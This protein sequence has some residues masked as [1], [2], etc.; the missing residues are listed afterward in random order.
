[1]TTFRYQASLDESLVAASFD[2]DL[3]AAVNQTGGFDV[4]IEHGEPC[5]IAF[6]LEADDSHA[7]L[8]LGGQVIRSVY[9]GAFAEGASRIIP[10]P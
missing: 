4:A 1:M 7:A 6:V 5:E 8:D 9:G 10:T 2:D 3:L